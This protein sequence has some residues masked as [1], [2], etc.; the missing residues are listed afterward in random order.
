MLRREE[1]KE[2][3]ADAMDISRR[4]GLR[5]VGLKTLNISSSLDRYIN[6]LDGIQAVY[7]PFKYLKGPRPK[8]NNKL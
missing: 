6:F 2:M 4:E 5:A 1:K 3:L 7:G 8:H